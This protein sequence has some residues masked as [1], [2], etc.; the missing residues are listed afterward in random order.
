MNKIKI[1]NA[2]NNARLFCTQW[3]GPILINQNKKSETKVH[4]KKLW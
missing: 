4:N 3:L 2:F 1:N